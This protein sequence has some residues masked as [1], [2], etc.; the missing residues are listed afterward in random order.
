MDK[1]GPK[2]SGTLDRYRYS[3]FYPLAELQRSP[4]ILVSNMGKIFVLGTVSLTC[5]M[6]TYKKV[7]NVRSIQVEH[8]TGVTFPIN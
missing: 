4:T 7:Q 6:N 3:V 8:C 5:V 1:G 2:T